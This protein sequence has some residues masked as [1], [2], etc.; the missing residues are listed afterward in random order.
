[1]E[2]EEW[3][4]DDVDPFECGPGSL[5]AAFPAGD[6]VLT[7]LRGDQIVRKLSVD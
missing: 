3:L 2:S 5:K 1:M 7:Y 4:P 6:F